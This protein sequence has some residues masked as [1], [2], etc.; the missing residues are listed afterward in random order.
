VSAVRVS[1]GVGGFGK[2]GSEMIPDIGMMIGGYIV[3]RMIDVLYAENKQVRQGFALA[4][5][6][7]TVVFL[8]DLMVKGAAK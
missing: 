3:V 7:L 6:I 4:V 5:L 1:L 2:G 8:L